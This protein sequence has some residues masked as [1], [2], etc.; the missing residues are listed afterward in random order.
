M[1]REGQGEKV[2]DGSHR[3]KRASTPSSNEGVIISSR[4]IGDDERSGERVKEGKRGKSGHGGNTGNWSPS[5]FASLVRRQLDSL[6][7]QLA[8]GAL[9]RYCPLFE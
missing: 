7:G 8:R 6:F 3:N 1:G 4:R 9:V 2:A 5:P